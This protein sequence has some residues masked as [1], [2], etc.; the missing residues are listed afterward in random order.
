MTEL[1]LMKFANAKRVGNSK[2]GNPNWDVAFQNVGG[3]FRTQTDGSVGYDVPNWKPGTLLAVKL[4]KADRIIYAYP[5]K[6][7]NGRAV[8]ID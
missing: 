4:S 1:N 3:T 7:I 8:R 6:I 5:V 2:N